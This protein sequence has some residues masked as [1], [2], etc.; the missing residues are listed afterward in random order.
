M[1]DSHTKTGTVNILK[2]LFY[3][4]SQIMP[5]RLEK[6][7]TTGNFKMIDWYEKALHEHIQG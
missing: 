1:R 7:T 4:G 2:W 5:P 3:T 6:S